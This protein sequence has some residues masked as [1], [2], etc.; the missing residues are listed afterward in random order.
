MMVRRDNRNG[1]KQEQ[2]HK[3][4][5]KKIA[6]ENSIEFGVIVWH[7]L[8]LRVP[9]SA[10]EIRKGLFS[11]GSRGKQLTVAR[12]KGMTREDV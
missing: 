1:S 11:R 2:F 6:G 5:L 12:G 3:S 9:S 4:V 7:L 8:S 10:R